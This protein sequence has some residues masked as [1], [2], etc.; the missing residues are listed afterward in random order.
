LFLKN[1]D[2]SPVGLYYDAGPSSM[3]HYDTLLGIAQAPIALSGN[4][5]QIIFLL[6]HEKKE[7]KPR[8]G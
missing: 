3:Q 4:R 2:A 5:T 8:C 1:I 6:E 7:K